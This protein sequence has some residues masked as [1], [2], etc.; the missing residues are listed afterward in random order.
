MVFKQIFGVRGVD[1]PQRKRPF[2]RA[3]CRYEDCIHTGLREIL[4]ACVIKLQ[5]L[6]CVSVW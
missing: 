5:L 2:C 3:A 6:V 4:C 1:S